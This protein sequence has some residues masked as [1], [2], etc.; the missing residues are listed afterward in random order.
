MTSRNGNAQ[1]TKKAIKKCLRSS[2]DSAWVNWIER[3][4]IPDHCDGDKFN[5]GM[6]RCMGRQG[7]DMTSKLSMRDSYAGFRLTCRSPRALAAAWHRLL[8]QS[9]SSQR[10]CHFWLFTERQSLPSWIE[11]NCLRSAA[12]GKAARLSIYWLTLLAA[13][14]SLWHCGKWY[15]RSWTN[16]IIKAAMRQA[17]S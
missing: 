9:C 13:W 1:A 2:M 10:Q 3:T 11:F 14:S 15:L 16:I 4:Q 7:T 8:F 5:T 17:A 12:V 6:S